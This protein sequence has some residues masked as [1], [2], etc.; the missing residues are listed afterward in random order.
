MEPPGT[1]SV[2]APELPMDQAKSNA[3][4]REALAPSHSRSRLLPLTGEMPTGDHTSDSAPSLHALG[5]AEPRVHRLNPPIVLPGLGVRIEAAGTNAAIFRNYLDLYPIEAST[6][7]DRWEL[8]GLLVRTNRAGVPFP[9]WLDAEGAIRS[10]RFFRTPAEPFGTPIPPP[11]GPHR[12]GTLVRKVENPSNPLRKAFMVSVWYPAVPEAGVPLSRYMDEKN[13]ALWDRALGRSVSLS[14]VS[15]SY[16]FP[17]AA[18][19]DSPRPFPVI[20]HS[21]GQG[22]VRT[23]NVDKF[24]LLASHGFVVVTLDSPQSQSWVMEDGELGFGELYEPLSMDYAS[25][26][27]DVR[28]LA[29]EIARWNLDDS[30][31][32]GR[33]DTDRVGVFGFS[34]GGAVATGACQVDPRFKAGVS[35]DGGGHPDMAGV[36]MDVPFM[37]QVVV[38]DDNPY[39]TQPRKDNRALF[40]RMNR[41]GY[42]VRY[43]NASH[44]MFA[45]LPWFRSPIDATAQRIGHSVRA[46]L[47]SFFNK[48]LR[49]VDD[50]MLDQH[51]G[52]HP[53]VETFL[54]K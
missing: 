45:E 39:L 9:S 4:P 2:D 1:D 41:A 31:L 14:P 27:G 8:L 6:D 47:L 34:F 37:F 21:A 23:D 20:L 40:D 44:G 25:R 51:S 49:G 38:T 52:A 42:F 13:A 30:I 24:E 18:A 43:R 12:I 54:T 28:F 15:R 26:L 11:T 50:H 33:L 32:A 19:A 35:L 5:A 17:G 53:D 10:H 46:Y 22:D 48:H 7:F 16:A 29:D 36:V 3:L